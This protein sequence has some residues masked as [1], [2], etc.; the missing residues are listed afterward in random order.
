M[1]NFALNVDKQLLRQV[2]LPPLYIHR[3]IH[4][5]KEPTHLQLLAVFFQGSWQYSVCLL[6]WG[7]SLAV[8]MLMRAQMLG[9]QVRVLWER[10]DSKF[11]EPSK[12]AQT[13]MRYLV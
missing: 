13:K 3:I 11:R 5:L 2:I 4:L 8:I 6:S 9:C 1:H 7:V 10:L 12:M